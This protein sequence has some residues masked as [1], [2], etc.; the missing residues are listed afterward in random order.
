MT[1]GTYRAERRPEGYAQVTVSSTALALPSIP[2][3]A[4]YAI[5]NITTQ[6]VRYRDDGT[7]PTASVGMP[8]AAGDE[9]VLVSP[10]QIQD[11]RVIRSTGSD[12]ELN[13]SYYSA[14]KA[15]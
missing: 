1:S 2:D 13:V 10:K 14:D 9:L 3:K 15:Y 5:V 8:L 11:F 6:P 4:S 12:A 7:A